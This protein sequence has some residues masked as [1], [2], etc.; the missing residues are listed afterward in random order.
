MAIVN[1]HDENK[2]KVELTD[3]NYLPGYAEAELERRNNELERI[4]YYEEIQEKVNNGEFNGAKG[5]KGDKGDTGDSGVYIGTDTPPIDKDVWIDPSGN[6]EVLASNIIFEDKESLQD[7]LDNGSLGGNGGGGGITNETDPTVPEHVK[8]ITE[9][10]ISNWN[11]KGGFD[12]NYE[13]LTNKPTIPTKTSELTND[14]GFLTE[15]Q[16]LTGY[17]TETFVNTQI[18]AAIGGALNGTY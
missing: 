6:P 16:D 5:E 4:A 14:S 8:N 10:D 15:H 17:A 3:L 11:N 1:V 7:K 18:A 9:Q 2:I 12:G 13:N